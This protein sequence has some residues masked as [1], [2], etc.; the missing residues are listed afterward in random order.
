MKI[1]KIVF[2]SFSKSNNC[3]SGYIFFE[4]GIYKKVDKESLVEYLMEYATDNKINSIDE[5]LNNNENIIHNRNNLTEEEIVKKYGKIDFSAEIIAETLRMINNKP[6]KQK[7]SQKLFAE[8]VKVK[9]DKDYFKN[10]E[11]KETRLMKRMKK[12]SK[13]AKIV[14]TT[15]GLSVVTAVCGTGY[16]LT[17]KLGKEIKNEK[18]VQ[19]D[20][21]QNIYEKSTYDELVEKSKN[22]SQ[23]KEM[24][25]TGSF[26]DHYNN[27][28]ADKHVEQDK[29]IRAALSWDEVI[30]LDLAYND[31]TPSQISEI[32]NSKNNYDYTIDSQKF[33]NN[34]KSAVLQ[35]A[36]AYVIE[37]NNSKV[38]LDVLITDSKEKGF[39]TKY[40][41]IFSKCKN[42]TGEQQ[43]YYVNEFYK[44]LAS[45]FPIEENNREVGMMHSESMNTIESYKLSIVPMVVASEMMF[46]NLN[47]DKTMSD[48]VIKYF[49]D[50]GLCNYV[51]NKYEKYETT[52]LTTEKGEYSPYYS[53]FKQKKEDEL[54]KKGHYNLKDEQ[55]DLSKLT[56]FQDIINGKK[57]EIAPGE[58]VAESYAENSKN[59]QTS[60][61]S[62]S[63]K[64]VI[65]KKTTTSKKTTDNRD[66]AVQAAGEKAVAEAESKVDETIRVEN[67]RRKT[68]AEEQAERERQRRQQEENQQATQKQ[69]E[70]SKE[71]EKVSETI[72]D[73]NNKINQ[74]ET[75]NEN[76]YGKNGNGQNYVDFDSNHSDS[77]GNLDNSVKDITTDGT[78]AVDANTPLPAPTEMPTVKQNKEQETTPKGNIVQE[79]AASE[80]PTQ[81]QVQEAERIVNEMAAVEDSS[82]NYVYQYTK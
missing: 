47:I 18:V 48:K 59:Y 1:K 53:T 19:A 80:A 70:A 4:N 64:E 42:S 58:Y 78:G 41:E 26:I 65:S 43:V 57:I 12:T 66:E 72:E 16:S 71:N 23:K 14:I 55:R 29:N 8:P 50:L 37:N 17:K 6:K 22:T 82:E 79:P 46:Q 7:K 49:N 68:E 81:A 20:E 15:I 11:S 35:L 5:L 32:F 74:G 33:T 3:Q 63:S 73:M 10:R 2:D 52:I 39:Y 54:I 36:S 76:D 44:Q 28:F 62:K 25:K 24:A 13:A 34:Y 61:S 69:E 75:V 38:S 45:D 9:I 67:E 27:T 21:F 51:E 30:A 40:N 77:N 31:F 56:E 60:K